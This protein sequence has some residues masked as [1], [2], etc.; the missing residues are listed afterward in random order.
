MCMIPIELEPYFN[1]FKYFLNNVSSID[2]CLL[3]FQNTQKNIGEIIKLKAKYLHSLKKAKLDFDIT[4]APIRDEIVY[5]TKVKKG[6]NLTEKAIEN[7]VLATN[8]ELYCKLQSEIDDSET[9]FEISNNLLMALFQRKD[10]LVE[11]INYFK[12]K[13]QMENCLMKNEIFLKK[14]EKFLIEME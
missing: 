9:W 14:F 4:F 5:T 10:I 1:I 2:E 12:S 13:N 11:T 8:K 6:L 7:Q 3:E